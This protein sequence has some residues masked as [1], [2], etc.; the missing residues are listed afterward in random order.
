MYN[1]RFP[2]CLPYVDGVLP[3]L[4]IQ[5]RAIP[6]EGELVGIHRRWH[7]NHPNIDNFAMTAIRF[8]YLHLTDYFHLCTFPW[9]VFFIRM[10][11]EMKIYLRIG[12]LEF[13][14][15]RLLFWADLT[16]PKRMSVLTVLSWAS[17]KTI[18]LYLEVKDLKKITCN[19]VLTLGLYSRSCRLT[20][21][22]DIPFRNPLLYINTY[23]ES[24]GSTM[25]SLNNMPSVWKSTLVELFETSSN[26]TLHQ[27]V[28]LH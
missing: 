22:S 28:L 11:N 12:R 21:L 17:S 15:C 13:L 25:A 26:R 4:N 16:T 2:S 27:I 1:V 6:V 10:A 5:Y 14:P 8:L 23:L 19:L 3:P 20:R 7:H 24:K 18:Q 9:P